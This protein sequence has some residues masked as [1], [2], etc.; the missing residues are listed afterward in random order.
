MTIVNKYTPK[1]KPILLGFLISLMG[2][3]PLGYINLI[4]LQVLLEQGSWAAISLIAGII[5]IEFFVLIIVSRIAKWLVGQKKIV[6]FIDVFTIVFFLVIATYFFINI[7]NSKN[8]SLG[9]LQLATYPFLLG[10]TLNTFNFIQWPYWSGI[11]VFLFREQK[12]NQDAKSQNKFVFGALI[13]TMAGMLLFASTGKFILVENKIEIGKYLNVTF[14]F[15]FLFLGIAQ[16]A[17][18]ILKHR[19]SISYNIKKEYKKQ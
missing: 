14:A 2:A 15:L 3:M 16:G 4:C 1:N 12:L 8:F 5:V 6:L 9:T 13:G 11:Y 19:K 7:G 10:I 18:L 17:K